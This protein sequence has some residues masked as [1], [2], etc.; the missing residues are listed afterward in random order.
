MLA[1][2][3]RYEVSKTNSSFH[4]KQRTAG[5]VL[6]LFFKSFLLVFTK[7]LQRDWALDHHSM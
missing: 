2:I 6:F 4:V 5:K 3:V 1:T 7:L